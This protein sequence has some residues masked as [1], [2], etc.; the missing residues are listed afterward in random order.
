MS[1]SPNIVFV[2]A[3]PFGSG[4]RLPDT[5]MLDLHQQL[6]S[7]LRY[8]QLPPGFRAATEKYRPAEL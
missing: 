6:T 7:V 4:P 8:E 2:F 3:D 5:D 1:D